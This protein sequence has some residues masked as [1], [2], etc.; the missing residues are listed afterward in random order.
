[1]R[2]RRALALAVA[3]VVGTTACG[4]DGDDALFSMDQLA[5]LVARAEDAPSS[6]RYDEDQSGPAPLDLLSQGVGSAQSR[7][8]QLG[9]L[10]GQTSVFVSTDDGPPPTGSV[11]GNGVFLFDDSAAAS[12]ALDVQRSVVIPEVMQGHDELPADDLGDEAFG[13]TFA[14]GPAGGA[15]AIYAFRIANAVFLVPGSGPSA[16]PEQLLALARTV[17]D[18]ADEQLP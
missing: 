7:F 13:F 17:A 1:M 14:S 4:G 10:G 6:M 16:E 5:E 3:T 15:G 11:V 8:E 18:R 9:F 12:D 2:R